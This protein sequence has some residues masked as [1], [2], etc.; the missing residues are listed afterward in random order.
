[1]GLMNL[2]GL[3]G[4]KQERAQAAAISDRSDAARG[5]KF[6]RS[7]TVTGGAADCA[8]DLGAALAGAK[9][10]APKRNPARLM[11]RAS[12]RMRKLGHEDAAGRWLSRWDIHLLYK[13]GMA[14]TKIREVF[15]HQAM[16]WAVTGR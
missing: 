7:T 4:K 6:K 3:F 13:Q 1:M 12:C 16:R 5:G 2:F 9:S 8:L 11:R 15:G 14:L 10:S